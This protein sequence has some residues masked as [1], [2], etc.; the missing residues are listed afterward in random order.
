MRQCAVCGERAE[1][2][3]SLSIRGFDSRCDWLFYVKHR[4][5][6]AAD[7]HE[8]EHFDGRV[9]KPYLSYVETPQP[10]KAIAYRNARIS[11][12]AGDREG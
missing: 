12:L 9:V 7:M 3:Y 4:S 6:I 2:D 8:H 5:P 11:A 1:S 10:A